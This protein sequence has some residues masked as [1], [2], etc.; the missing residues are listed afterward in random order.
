MSKEEKPEELSAFCIKLVIL[1]QKAKNLFQ[2]GKEIG[3]LEKVKSQNKENN[4]K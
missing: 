1:F 2:N 3:F 4:E